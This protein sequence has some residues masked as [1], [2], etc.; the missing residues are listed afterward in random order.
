[1]ACCWPV[2]SA[3]IRRHETCAQPINGTFGGAW[4]NLRHSTID[5]GGINLHVVQ[6]GRQGAPAVVLLHG[7]PEHWVCW[8]RQIP[9]LAAA[10]FWVLAPDQRGYNRS[11]KPPGIPAY[12]LDRLSADVVHLL[13]SL[14]I[15]RAHVVGHD[16]GAA[17]AWWLA[18]TEQRRL[19]RLA[20]LNVP[21]PAAL[22]RVIRRRPEQW[23]RSWYIGFFQ[24]PRL[25][26]A[27]LGAVDGAA[28][29]RTIQ[30]GAPA[31]TFDRQDIDDLRAAWRRPRAL[32]SMINWYRALV[33]CPPPPPHSWIV[34]V[35][36]K[37]LWGT[38]DSYL[39]PLNATVSATYCRHVDLV[40][41][42]GI[43]H[44]VQH[45]VPET[46]NRQLIEW[47]GSDH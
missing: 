33:R 4:V 41:L 10:G 30:R 42:E 1:M 31:G 8:R 38:G 12:G 39:V 37:I 5:V 34:E 23:L 21:H 19:R 29:A 20:I 27:L 45:E 26:E 15:G 35:P 2:S 9:S 44:W 25:P 16:W 6:A 46:V 3:G 43:S 24:L 7:F 14:D 13:D 36:T 18:L 40:N 17:V 28:L 11:D 47:F 22:R 32:R